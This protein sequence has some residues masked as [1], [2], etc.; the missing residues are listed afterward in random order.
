MEDGTNWHK[1]KGTMQTY[2]YCVHTQ[3]W[4]KLPD[5]GAVEFPNKQEVVRGSLKQ[6]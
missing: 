6:K 5:A 3:G 1:T 2:T 4:G